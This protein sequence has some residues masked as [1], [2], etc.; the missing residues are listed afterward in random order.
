MNGKKVEKILDKFISTYNGN[1]YSN[2]DFFFEHNL[3]Y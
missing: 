2:N 3:T 1:I